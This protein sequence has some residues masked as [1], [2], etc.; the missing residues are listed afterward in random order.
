M[1]LC[2]KEVWLPGLD[3]SVPCGSATATMICPEKMQPCRV[4]G[5]SLASARWRIM[6][7]MTPAD[8]EIR[9]VRLLWMRG[10][11]GGLVGSTARA[12]RIL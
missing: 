6:T 3:L 5:D 10:L 7:G 1:A 11:V 8:V 9:V 12:A 4:C 2:L